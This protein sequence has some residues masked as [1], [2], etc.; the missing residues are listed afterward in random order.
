MKASYI[1][2]APLLATAPAAAGDTFNSPPTGNICLDPHK[3]YQ[4]LYLKGSRYDIVAH[5]TLGRDHRV[6]K[7]S[8]TCFALRE[9]LTIR[10][11]TS[12]NCVA[13]GDEVYTSTID[14]HAQSCRVTHV[15]PYLPAAE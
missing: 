15:E 8:T 2:L 6:L 10:L 1:I 13:M 11:A 7:I 4:A 12:F 3:D 5:Q 9:A 14:G